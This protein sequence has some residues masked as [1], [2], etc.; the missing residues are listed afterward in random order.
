LTDESKYNI[1][2][3]SSDFT[4]LVYS[5]GTTGLGIITNL[6]INQL[7]EEDGGNYMCV[8]GTSS[9]SPE[10]MSASIQLT[11]VE[12]ISPTTMATTPEPMTT[13]TNTGTEGEGGT[14]GGGGGDEISKWSCLH[15]NRYS[16]LGKGFTNQVQK[17]KGYYEFN[18]TTGVAL[19]V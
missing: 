7:T 8:A 10:D 6:T 12:G 5:N 16:G 17:V 13:T 14:E 9:A 15:R 18:H 2:V 1:T 19:F 4:E 11:I 3:G